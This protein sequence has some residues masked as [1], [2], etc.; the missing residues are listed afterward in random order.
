MFK[1]VLQQPTKDKIYKREREERPEPL[2]LE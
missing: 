2:W 1:R